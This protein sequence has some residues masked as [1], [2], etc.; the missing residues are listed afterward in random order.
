MTSDGSA[1]VVFGRVGAGVIWLV[2]LNDRNDTIRIDG[3]RRRTDAAIGLGDE[4][5]LSVG[6]EEG[7][8]GWE[9]AND[10]VSYGY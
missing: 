1:D 6:R 4:V 3:D 2:G 8:A 7:L 5:G 10:I 9:T